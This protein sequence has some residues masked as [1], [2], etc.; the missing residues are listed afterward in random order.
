M[1]IPCKNLLVMPLGNSTFVCPGEFVIAMGS[2]LSLIGSITRGIIRLVDRI[3]DQ[4]GYLSIENL[5]ID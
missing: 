5:L 4:I 2:P 3:Y 1:R